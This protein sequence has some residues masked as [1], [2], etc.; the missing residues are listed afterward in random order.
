VKYEDL[1]EHQEEIEKLEKMIK[2][3]KKRGV[4]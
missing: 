4:V 1:R 3:S 2:G